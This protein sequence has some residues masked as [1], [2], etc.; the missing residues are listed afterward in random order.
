MFL[1]GHKA[2]MKLLTIRSENFSHAI[3]S[4]FNYPLLLQESVPG[5]DL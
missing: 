2:Q 5:T 1:Q 3:K 4:Q